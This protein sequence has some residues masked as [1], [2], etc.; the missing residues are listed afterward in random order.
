VEFQIV[1]YPFHLGHATYPRPCVVID[2]TTRD[3][4]AIT[5]K[6]YAKFNQFILPQ[7]HPDFP[8]TGL[9]ETSYVIGDTI[10]RADPAVRLR[11]TGVIK[12]DLAKAFTKW[13][14]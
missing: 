1:R 12:G 10:A 6:Q 7:D 4:L 8:A 5:T 9:A 2:A 11:K 13:I 14:G 3:M